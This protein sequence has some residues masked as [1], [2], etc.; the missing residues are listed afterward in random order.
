MTEW[1][2]V[3]VLKTNLY[4]Y[5]MS[6][7]LILLYVLRYLF[8][9]HIN[10]HFFELKQSFP[11]IFLSC[12]FL[13]FISFLKSNSITFFYLEPF[14]IKSKEIFFFNP[15]ESVFFHVLI[16]SHFLSIYFIPYVCFLI[17]C[18]F[19]SGLFKLEKWFF[20]LSLLNF[21]F[22]ST[23][24][25]LCLF[26]ILLPFLLHLFFSLENFNFHNS[27]FLRFNLNGLY[28]VLFCLKVYYCFLFICSLPFFLFC[29]FFFEIINVHFF[30]SHKKECFFFCLIFSS[31]FS[32]FD[33]FFQCL[34]CLIL[35]C[36]VEIVAY[37]SLIIFLFH[38]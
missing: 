5:N 20:L 2:K 19:R 37:I 35:F 7:N 28:S 38:F 34:L 36:V 21:L 18:Y 6:S 23:L 32:P 30:L 17:F 3:L 15:I 25:L 27:F 11:Y 4:F 31:I 14:F 12:F 1:F 16:H 33:I 9:L 13:L 24:L 26:S 29:C 22:V 10:K 8:M